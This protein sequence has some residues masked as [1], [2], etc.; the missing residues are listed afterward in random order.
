MFVWNDELPGANELN[1]LWS[2]S[3]AG[4]KI[5]EYSKAQDENSETY[6]DI[7]ILHV[8]NFNFGYFVILNLW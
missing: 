4:P 8:S 1:I 3:Y 7:S 5:M 2:S 6:M